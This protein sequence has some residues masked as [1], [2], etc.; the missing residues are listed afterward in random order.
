MNNHSVFFNIDTVNTICLPLKASQDPDINEQDWVN[1]NFEKDYDAII[2]GWGS[3]T[4][5]ANQGKLPL[6]K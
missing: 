4:K 2:A 3:T 6:Q 5:M 1:I